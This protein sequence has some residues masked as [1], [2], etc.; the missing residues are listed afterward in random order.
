MFGFNLVP[1]SPSQFSACQISS[2]SYQLVARFTKILVPW[3]IHPAVNQRVLCH[4]PSRRHQ[5]ALPWPS[6]S[7]SGICGMPGRPPSLR[8][9]PQTHTSCLPVPK[10]LIYRTEPENGRSNGAACPYLNLP[11]PLP[12]FVH[13]SCDPGREYLLSAANREKTRPVP[14]DCCSCTTFSG[15]V[16]H[17]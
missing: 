16:I 5:T 2:L 8:C 15:A 3:F 10:T 13:P 12:V 14:A 11:L 9:V 4:V 1:S 17:H 7:T 6:T